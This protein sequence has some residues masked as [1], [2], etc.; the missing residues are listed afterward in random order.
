MHGFGGWC[1]Q[2]RFNIR[3]RAPRGSRES[4]R[5]EFQLRHIVKCACA[6][7]LINILGKKIKNQKT[8]Q[9]GN[10]SHIN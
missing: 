5:S 3:Q 9:K 1:E 10:S 8:A 6:E 2:S 7:K 4:R